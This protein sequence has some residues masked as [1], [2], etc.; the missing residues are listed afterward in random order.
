MPKRYV[1]LGNAKGQRKEAMS[2]QYVAPTQQSHWNEKENYQQEEYQE[3]AS[4]ERKGSVGQENHMPDEALNSPYR[5]L[6]KNKEE[7]SRLGRN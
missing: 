5:Y 2:S 3:L 4:L 7:T 6:Q 1:P